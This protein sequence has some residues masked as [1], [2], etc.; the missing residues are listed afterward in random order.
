MTTTKEH[1][2]SP[3]REAIADYWFESTRPLV[4][5]AFIVPMLLVYE[6]GVLLLGPQAMR[7]GAD[8]WLRQLL[9]LTGFGQYFLLPVLTMSVLLG[10]HHTT[11]QN[12]RLSMNVLYAMLVESALLG[13]LLLVVAQLQGLL[14][15]SIAATDPAAMAALLPSGRLVGSLVGF[16]GAGIY[17]EL[18]FRL[19]LLPLVAGVVRMLG[20]PPRASI[21][22]SVLLTSLM[23][24]AAHYNLFTAA[25]EAFQWYTFLFRYVAG[26]FF[27]VLFIYRGFG[28]SAGTHTLYDIFVALF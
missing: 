18:L 23:F 15:Q 24:S 21:I 13:G 28:I 2:E 12:W 6:A 26:L 27:S 3:L 5:L 20:V 11:R 25:G 16:F 22:A 4:S 9:D 1:S 14:L 8:V 10:W 19:M 17:E 7:N